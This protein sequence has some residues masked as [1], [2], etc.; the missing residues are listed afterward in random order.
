MP[1]P[2]DAP[3][4]EPV[5]GQG[6]DAFSDMPTMSYEVVSKSADPYADIPTMDSEKVHFSDMPQ[7]GSQM[8]ERTEDF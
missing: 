4:S 6:N 3:P 1:N 2:E 5:T 7:F 8:V